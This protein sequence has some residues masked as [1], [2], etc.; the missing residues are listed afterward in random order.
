MPDDGMV[1]PRVDKSRLTTT[2]PKP[3]VL[4]KKVAL[5]KEL[6]LGSRRR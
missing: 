6:V 2:F 4:E 5:V 3:G 1:G